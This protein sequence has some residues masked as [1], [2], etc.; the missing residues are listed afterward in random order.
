MKTVIGLKCVV[1]FVRLF[2]ELHF[3]CDL[4]RKSTGQRGE[5][6]VVISQTHH[7][8]DRNLTML[9]DQLLVPC[10][11]QLCLLKARAR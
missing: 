1:V 8:D 5:R 3:A 10:C 4:L 9:G 7:I 2:V 11:L 6:A